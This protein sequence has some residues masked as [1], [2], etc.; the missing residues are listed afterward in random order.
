MAG[1]YSPNQVQEAVLTGNERVP[2]DT[3][4]AGGGQPATVYATSSQ[5]GNFYGTPTAITYA[6]TVTPNIMTSAYQTIILTGNATFAAFANPAPGQ[7]LMLEIQQDGTGSRTVT[8]NANVSWPGGTAPTLST[9]A[10]AIDV[11]RFSYNSV[12]N[13]WRGETVGK[14]YA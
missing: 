5:L 1:F 14:A 2:M 6:A 8:W 4:L 9:A 3:G 11:F 13:K 7:E 10:N 12:A